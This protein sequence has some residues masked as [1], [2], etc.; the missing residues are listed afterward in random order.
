MQSGCVQR[1][2]LSMNCEWNKYKPENYKVFLTI[3]LKV[4]QYLIK[5]GGRCMGHIN[6][7]IYY[8][9]HTGAIGACP[10]FLKNLTSFQ[11]SSILPYIWKKNGIKSY[12]D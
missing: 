11:N 4:K 5:L 1:G 12:V 8:Y 3:K 6:C 2:K 7:K 9:Q 10:Q